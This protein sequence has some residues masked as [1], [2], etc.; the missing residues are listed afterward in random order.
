MQNQ[1]YPNIRYERIT[2]DAPKAQLPKT[3]ILF[4]AVMA[5]MAIAAFVALQVAFPGGLQNRSAGVLVNDATP[6]VS[7]PAAVPSAAPVPTSDAGPTAFVALDGSFESDIDW[8]AAISERRSINIE[9]LAVSR[10]SE[11]WGM[12][13]L[14]AMDRFHRERR[15][16]ITMPV[17]AER[18]S[19]SADE[20]ALIAVFADM[21]RGECEA[22]TRTFADACA[23]LNVRWNM[24][25]GDDWADVRMRLVFTQ[26]EEFG[27]LPAGGTGGVYTE[28]QMP[29]SS[30][31]QAGLKARSLEAATRRKALYADVARKC[32]AMRRREQNCAVQLVR[33]RT[34]PD[35]QRGSLTEGRVALGQVKPRGA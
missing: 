31:G 7:L 25:Q 13:S 35:G 24:A 5:F 11:R 15:V 3:A 2:E 18:L 29:L 26:K 1:P 28:R 4:A 10:I 14:A 23:L 19:G 32:D 30:R 12:P 9:G 33:L 21:A 16:D 6:Q 8:S 22:I 20:N 34:T 27:T 17:P